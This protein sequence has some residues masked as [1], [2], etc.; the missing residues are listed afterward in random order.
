MSAFHNKFAV[1][2][3][4]RTTTLRTLIGNEYNGQLRRIGGSCPAAT[5]RRTVTVS[6]SNEKAAE[7]SRSRWQIE[8]F[9]GPS[10]T[11]D[12]ATN[13][14]F[15]SNADTRLIEIV[16][17]CRLGKTYRMQHTDG[18]LMLSIANPVLD[19]KQLECVRSKERPG[20][21]LIDRNPLK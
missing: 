1:A 3:R 16:D 21:E 20:L 13:H 17:Q 6:F 15:L 9:N 7:A 2:A 12:P 5:E 18:V 4:Q 19:A 8:V 11:G 10:I 14:I